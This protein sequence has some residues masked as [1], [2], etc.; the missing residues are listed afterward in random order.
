MVLKRL[1]GPMMVACQWKSSVPLG[2]AEHDEGG[3]LY[4]LLALGP[5]LSDGG[6]VDLAVACGFVPRGKSATGGSGV[7]LPAEI[8]QLLVDA[9]ESHGCVCERRMGCCG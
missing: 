6:D 3:S 9:L 8:C 2:P 1:T 4:V 5:S 7:C